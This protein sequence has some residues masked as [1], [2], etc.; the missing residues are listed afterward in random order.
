[1]MEY[2]RELGKS[3]FHTTRVNQVK[4]QRYGQSLLAHVYLYLIL[5]FKIQFSTN[6]VNKTIDAFL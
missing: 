3:K 4:F 1:M 2:K 6:L 5:L